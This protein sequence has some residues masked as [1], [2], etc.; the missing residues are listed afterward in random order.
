MTIHL[1]DISAPAPTEDSLAGVHD[2]IDLLLDRG[3][4]AAA[5]QRWDQARRAYATWFALA[6][7]RFQQDTADAAAQAERERADAINPIAIGHEIAIKRRLLAWNDRA[8]LEAGVS[9]HVVRL[10]ETDIE[11]FSPG[12]AARLE[13]ESR[14]QAEYTEL[15]AGARLEIG[16]QVVNLSG[17][18]PF[19]EHLDRAVRREAAQVEWAFFAENGAALDGIFDGLVRL[20]TS[21]ARDLGYADFIALGYK[22]MRRIDYDAA[23]VARYREEIVAHVVP[24]LARLMARRGKIMGWERVFA[25]DEPLLDPQGNPAPLGDHDTLVAAGQTMFD[26]MDARLGRFFKAMHEGGFLDLKMRPG[27]APGGFCDALPTVGMP[28]IFANFNGTYQDISVFTHEMGHAL[29]C[30]ESRDIG[31]IDTLWPTTEACEVHSMALE[32]LSYPQ[33]GLLVGDA[34]A[35]RFRKMHLELFL[36]LLVSCALGDHFQHEVYARPEATPAERHAM[37]R[38]LERRYMPWRDYGDIAYAAAGGTW[39]RV[40]HYFQVP[41]YYIDYALACCCAMQFWV[42]AGQDSAE[43]LERY[44]ALCAKGGSAA[45]LQLVAGAGLES[46]FKAGVLAKVVRQA[47]EALDS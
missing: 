19:A 18:Q 39:Q 11:T 43:A 4:L 26:N 22:R 32:M 13:E 5:L 9:A 10:W 7:L 45:F 2:A 47:A 31:N 38:A 25:W 46:P 33:M 6:Q 1:D 37:Y 40:L 24:L 14:L 42:A 3:E 15:T 28:V 21:M 29:Q 36:S 35:V 12:I 20:R 27:K 41:F 8:A 30:Y 23:D 16:G 34:A 44:F 17:L